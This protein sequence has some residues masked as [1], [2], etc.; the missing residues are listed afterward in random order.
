M[1][2]NKQFAVAAKVRRKAAKRFSDRRI[3]TGLGEKF[4]AGQAY[5][6]SGPNF[7]RR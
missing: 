1:S 4:C 2:L 3:V 5:Q 6:M 7:L